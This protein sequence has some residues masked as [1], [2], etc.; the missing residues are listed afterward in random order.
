MIFCRL[1]P[2][3]G[4]CSKWSENQ[5]TTSG[6]YKSYSITWLTNVNNEPGFSYTNPR[7]GSNNSLDFLET[8]YCFLQSG[9][10]GPGDVLICDNARIH[11]AREIREPLVTVLEARGVVL[12]FLPAYAPELNP[13]EEIFA[14]SKM[15]L[16]NCRW[17]DPFM[18]EIVKSFGHVT[19][20]NVLNYYDR[21]INQ[22]LF[23]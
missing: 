21:S 19:R 18:L 10:L 5:F 13:A 12:Y 20:S 6:L 23:P 11:F 15:H 22:S 7:K 8:I 4:T 16:R 17:E 3:C 9:A 14:Q 2:K 1:S